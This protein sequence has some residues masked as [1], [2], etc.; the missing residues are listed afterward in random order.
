MKIRSETVDGVLDAFYCRLDG[1][2]DSKAYGACVGD[3]QLFVDKN[4]QSADK[5]AGLRLKW[6]GRQ[7]RTSQS[8]IQFAGLQTKRFASAD[9]I[10]ASEIWK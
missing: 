3:L 8:Q 7:A 4:G 2:V 9:G 10:C 6:S 5:P 1:Q